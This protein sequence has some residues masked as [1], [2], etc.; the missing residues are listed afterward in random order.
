MPRTRLVA[1]GLV[2]L[3]IAAVAWLGW[4]DP[5]GA[6]AP[7]RVDAAGPALPT[8]AVVDAR[9]AEPSADAPPR[10]PAAPA[11]ADGDGRGTLEVHC[12]W[13]DDGAPVVGFELVVHASR[14]KLLVP[15]ANGRLATDA[16]GV[17]RFAELAPGPYQVHAGKQRTPVDVA[18]GTRRVDLTLAAIA[19]V[20]GRVV[21]GSERPIG[22]ASVSLQGVNAALPAVVA[23]SA[24]SDGTFAFR[25]AST[26]RVWAT[27]A[28]W[29]PCP[30]SAVDRGE[31]SLELVLQPGGATLTG[32]VLAPDGAPVAGALVALGTLAE[33]SG[34]EP[35]IVV[36]RSDE[37]GRFRLDGARPGACLVYAGAEGYAV[38]EA[39]AV[40]PPPS[41]VVVHLRRGATV[42]GVLTNGAG[43]PVPNVMVQTLR[44]RSLRGLPE[45]VSYHFT[46][47]WNH[48]GDDGRFELRAAY[49]GPM[50]LTAH[51]SRPLST[52]AMLRDGEVFVWNP[53]DAP[54]GGG[55]IR[56]VLL[57]PDGAPLAGWRVRTSRVNVE[58]AQIESAKA[59]SDAGGRFELTPLRDLPYDLQ[60]FAP[61]TQHPPLAARKQVV[62]GGPELEWRVPFALTDC[63]TLTAVVVGADG[64][65]VR[66]LAVT[67][68]CDQVV[69]SAEAGADGR[70]SFDL[71]PPGTWTVRASTRDFGT[72]ALGAWRIDAQANVD[73][74][75]LRLPAPGRVVVR[76]AAGA[77]DGAMPRL[78][79]RDGGRNRARAFTTENGALASAPVPPGR[80]RLTVC[81]VAT[82]PEAR[83]VDVAAGADTTVELRPTPATTVAVTF[84]PEPRTEDTWRDWLAIELRDA[85]GSVLHAGTETV[86]TKAAFVWRVGLRPG[87]YV[88]TGS[89]NQFGQR[90]GEA[91]FT[92]PDR[93]TAPIDVRVPLVPK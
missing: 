6:Q 58:T 41:P 73:A 9:I 47:A 28:G 72:A 10:E 29:L 25:T 49:P 63:G 40:A 27:A 83:D 3:A 43:A 84:A 12:R 76:F 7:P 17:A 65:P 93:A 24:A 91:A 1:G 51:A 31:Q 30:P 48:T 57:G 61:D 37:H 67:A 5:P 39:E 2:T 8:P 56:G 70:V 22:G 59:T 45:N 26:G 86:E 64:A 90:R 13:A 87:R 78:A 77:P 79:E 11:T 74:G 15:V 53:V 55:A 35:P 68:E 32:T 18:A 85:G 38:G 16:T 60:L 80:Y 82:A 19:T 34:A 52:N 66:K 54:V 4:P 44:E 36:T 21:D 14:G 92:V 62:P 81:G 89:G 33:Q 20:R 71:L 75:T 69:R 50:W 23:T 42:R 88:V 46:Y